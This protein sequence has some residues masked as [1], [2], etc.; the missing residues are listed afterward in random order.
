MPFD[1]D[2]KVFAVTGLP[3]TARHPDLGGPDQE[4]TNNENIQAWSDT[5]STPL[6][7][8]ISASISA[9]NTD[10]FNG[11]PSLG[12]VPMLS[13]EGS[14]QS[15]N[16]MSVRQSLAEITNL[17]TLLPQGQ[18]VP[19]QTLE[20][21]L[22]QTEKNTS[23]SQNIPNSNAEPP[24]IGGLNN[25][26][27]YA[28]MGT[29]I[30]ST[31]SSFISA[32]EVPPSSIQINN[33][34]G[35][36]TR[37]TPISRS[38]NSTARGI[39]F[40]ENNDVLD[41]QNDEGGED[42]IPDNIKHGRRS[43]KRAMSSSLD[44]YSK[45][46]ARI[47]LVKLK[48]NANSIL[49]DSMS[50]ANNSITA[51]DEKENKILHPGSEV[52]A[53]K[54]KCIYFNTLQFNDINPF[55][56]QLKYFSSYRSIPAL[57]HC[58][59]LS[60]EETIFSLLNYYNKNLPEVDK[61]FPWLHGIHKLN[62]GQISFL[63]NN[64]NPTKDRKPRI[65]SFERPA[66][67]DENNSSL[68]EYSDD[69]DNDEE[70]DDFGSRSKNF[71]KARFSDE[72]EEE[73]EEEDKSEEQEEEL[74]DM[75]KLT[76]TPDVRFLMPVRSCNTNGEIAPNFASIITEST[77]L[78]KGTVSPGDVLISYSNI[79]NL[80]LYLQGILPN[81]VFK[82]YHP[83]TV[84]TDCIITQLIPVFK[85]LDPEIGINLRNF[86]IQV[87]KISNISDFIVYCFNRE[88]HE[89]NVNQTE[90]TFVNN[91]CK[92]V[93]L[94][95]L[96]H[97]AQ[98]VYQKQHPELVNKKNSPNLLNNKK[99]NT[100]IL[101]DP[102]IETLDTADLL[103]IPVVDETASLKRDDELCS[104]Y[105]ISVFN[106]WDSN[107]LYRERLEIS[108]M[109]TATPLSKSLWLGNITDYECLQIQLSNGKNIQVASTEEVQTMLE[110]QSD[111]P[112][113]CNAENTIVRLT[114]H[115]FDGVTTSEEADKML[116]TFPLI[117]WKFYIKC[118]EGARIPTLDQLRLIYDNFTDCDFVNIEFP[119][120]GSLSL[121]DMSDDDILSIVN[122]CKFCYYIC[123]DNFPGLIY[124]SDGY[125]ESSLLFLCYLMYS[126]DICLDEAI[127]KLHMDYGRPFFIFKTDYILLS[128]LETIMNKFSPLK[129]PEE[130]KEK[131]IFEEN[132]KSI[133]SSLLM[134]KR[135]NL[136]GQAGSNSG[137]NNFGN[138]GFNSPSSFVTS[139]GHHVVQYRGNQNIQSNQA[140]SNHSLFNRNNLLSTA[141]RRKKVPASV[142][143]EIDGCFG[144]V[145][146]SLP[147]RILKHLYL[148]SLTHASSIPLLSRLKIDYIVSVG[149]KIS[150]CELF[151]HQKE[152]HKSGS[153]IITFLEGQVDENSGYELN[154]KKMLILPNINDDGIGT[155]IT[156]IDHTLDFI[157]E[158][159]END[160]R[161]LVHCQVGVSRSAT[162]CIGEVMKRLKLSLAR[163][164]M[165][166][167][168]RRLNVIIQPN[169]KLMYEL[170]KWEE[171]LL[172]KKH[173]KWKKVNIRSDIEND[174]QNFEVSNLCENIRNGSVSSSST[175]FTN[176]LGKSERS[177][178][179]TT[180]GN[181]ISSN[182]GCGLNSGF[183]N[184]TTKM[185]FIGPICEE[186][187][188]DFVIES[189]EEDEVDDNSGVV[190]FDVNNSIVKYED[191]P[192]YKYVEQKEYDV[193]S[194]SKGSMREVDWCILCREIYNLNRAYIKAN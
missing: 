22:P 44:E 136:V 60:N 77:G 16:A 72:V 117:V 55:D 145:H 43:S 167:R 46:K 2:D 67:L 131:F 42:T 116:I 66:S 130:T 97:I 101:A 107:Y 14:T 53:A 110:N 129:T 78:I 122:I 106:N 153:E 151:K 61:L 39:L 102:N 52:L 63:S 111:T 124:C 179:S 38:L 1:Q 6:A 190:K 157:N 26:S 31:S 96:L 48:P 185:N 162:V 25:T 56:H 191:N 65:I 91:K 89:F 58:K 149:E 109:S 128:K 83:E 35:T 41:E 50:D 180:R 34:M 138:T 160:G 186:P 5:L 125:T 159:Y 100:F 70:D 140:R 194:N 20:A 120:S 87:S 79:I 73:L 32:S 93:S 75:A 127:L 174:D 81:E 189:E 169:L 64:I 57:T 74:D 47:S 135:K 115:D 80:E 68:E 23:S 173:T 152:I 94:S 193:V 154:V 156:T 104:K 36:A 183:W 143:P 126:E 92:C 161:A 147:S 17:D 69:D 88:D 86:H 37:N 30:S 40:T 62:Y 165:Y 84:I 155:L 150:W 139:T 24:I 187:E 4:E 168:V 178:V 192:R 11:S 51:G 98:I 33:E 182:S 118:V 172:V 95:R 27:S 21:D 105:D 146:G 90:D 13:Y 49:N 9:P 132:S 103:S 54:N 134:P 170:F 29:S 123:D 15:S 10:M 113:Y 137:T 99:Y 28:T 114:K 164:Y 8:S 158:C 3:A 181:S 184:N 71:R 142:K 188:Q 166:V 175:I 76:K 177:S 7:S 19:E 45:V 112:L 144:E 141:E 121:A 133:R 82:Y 12:S 85:N 18:S 148:G 119:P 59:L 108:K 171:N 176:Q 163:A